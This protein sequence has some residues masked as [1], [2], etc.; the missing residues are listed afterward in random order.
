V[1]TIF[2]RPKARTNTYKKRGRILTE[3]DIEKRRK[4]EARAR[5]MKEWWLAKYEAMSV[6]EKQRY[7][8]RMARKGLYESMARWLS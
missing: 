6:L 2:Y 3:R 1:I 7:R 5:K 4:R 8:R